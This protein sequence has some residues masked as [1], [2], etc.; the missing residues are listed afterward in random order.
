MAKQ[1]LTMLSI[2]SIQDATERDISLELKD[3]AS[4]LSVAQE[5]VRAAQ[6]SYELALRRL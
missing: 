2:K 5:N 1:A 3:S 4:S 6:A